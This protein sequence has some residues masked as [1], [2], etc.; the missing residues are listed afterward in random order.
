MIA[1]SALT[2]ENV[3]L[4]EDEPNLAVTLKV[5]LKKIGLSVRHVSNLEAAGIEF[6]NS[7]PDLVVLDRTLPDGDGIEFCE[8]LKRDKQFKGAILMLTARSEVFDRVQGLNA[9]A[10]D[11]LTKPFSWSELEARIRALHRRWKQIGSEKSSQPAPQNSLWKLDLGLLRILGPNG[12][13]TLTPLEFKLA[14]NLIEQDGLIVSRE[15]LLKEV[16]GFTLLPKTRTVDHFLGRLRKYFELNP[17]DPQH[18]L[19]V[20][21]AGYRF[22]AKPEAVVSST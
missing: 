17:D 8:R 11:Y 2:F 6:R 19:T 9:G 18:F 10:D 12:W 22:V 20:R 7:I 3:L 1:D 13:M 5:A 14:Q 21:G 16:W 4:V 15:N